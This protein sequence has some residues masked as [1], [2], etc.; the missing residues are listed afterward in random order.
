MTKKTAISIKAYI[1]NPQML[2]SRN[3]LK[4]D[5]FWWLKPLGP[6]RKTWSKS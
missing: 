3:I 5:D 2:P 6:L 1:N 4:T